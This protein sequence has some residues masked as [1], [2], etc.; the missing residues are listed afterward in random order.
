MGVLIDIIIP[1]VEPENRCILIVDYEAATYLGIL[2]FDDRDFRDKIGD[3]LDGCRGRTIKEI[4]DT[5]LCD[6]N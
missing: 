3:L 4:G 6:L 2:H 1:K 5:E